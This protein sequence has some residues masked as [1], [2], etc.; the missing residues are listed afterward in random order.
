MQDSLLALLVDMKPGC[1]LSLF[2]F[3]YLV[4]LTLYVD[5][6]LVFLTFLSHSTVLFGGDTSPEAFH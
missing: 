3:F 4:F 1:K 2:A 6:Y 5:F